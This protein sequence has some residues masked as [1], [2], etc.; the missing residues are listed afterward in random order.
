MKTWRENIEAHTSNVV[1]SAEL[2]RSPGWAAASMEFASISEAKPHRSARF[3]LARVPE[4]TQFNS[5][6]TGDE[7][8]VVVGWGW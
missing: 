4:L 6:Q 1:L 5:V 7:S 3:P 8:A 2:V